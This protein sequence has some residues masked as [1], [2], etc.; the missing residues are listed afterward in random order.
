MAVA[1]G[2]AGCDV[3]GWA[4][5]AAGRAPL[6]LSRCVG[7]HA[8]AIIARPSKAAETARRTAE[9][10]LATGWQE[11]GMGSGAVVRAE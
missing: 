6:G 11:C 3:T 10:F 8:V 7:P 9:V 5:A 1:G 2:A 4:E